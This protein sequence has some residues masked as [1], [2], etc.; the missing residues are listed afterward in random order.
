MR[1]PPA[2][3]TFHWETSESESEW[4]I[5]LGCMAKCVHIKIQILRSTFSNR[6]VSCLVAW[7]RMFARCASERVEWVKLHIKMNG[8]RHTGMF[9]VSHCVMDGDDGRI[10]YI[11]SYRHLLISNQPLPY[12]KK[13]VCIYFEMQFYLKAIQFD[14]AFAY[15]VCINNAECIRL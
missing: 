5:H 10:L 13:C 7:L 12:A 6:E 2:I 11:V 8:N 14:I 1:L 3:R 4:A 9:C 15:A